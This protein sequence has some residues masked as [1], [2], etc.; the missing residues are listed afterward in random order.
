MTIHIFFW[1]VPPKGL[2]WQSW[3]TSQASFTTYAESGMAHHIRATVSAY[4]SHQATRYLAA[5]LP[6]H[7]FHCVTV[8]GMTVLLLLG[9]N[10]I[11]T[12]SVCRLTPDP[13]S[14]S[15]I[16]PVYLGT[17]IMF[18]FKHEVL[19]SPFQHEQLRT[20]GMS[21]LKALNILSLGDKTHVK[22]L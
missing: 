2:S 6:G 4:G 8:P 11:C 12:A 7:L 21:G 19:R 14:H 17:G 18:S 20:P 16:S 15:K 13:Q 22:I 5:S 9:I 3:S 1:S 10:C